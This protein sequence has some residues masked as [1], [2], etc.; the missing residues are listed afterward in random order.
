MKKRMLRLSI[1]SVLVVGSVIVL[2]Y[3]TNNQSLNIRNFIH[4]V[5]KPNLPFWVVNEFDPETEEIAVKPTGNYDSLK[6]DIIKKKTALGVRYKT[7]NEAE[8]AQILDEANELF[9]ES[10]LNQIIP[11]WYGTKWDYNGYTDVPKQGM[12]ACGYFVSTPL[13]HMGF[14]LNRYKLAQTYSLQAVK[15]LQGSDAISLTGQGQDSL[16]KYLLAGNDGFYAIGLDHHIGLLLKRKDKAYFIHSNNI[17]PG[18][19]C[20]ER[21]EKTIQVRF[22]EAMVLAKLSNN[23]TFL[24]KWILNEEF[25]VPT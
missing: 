9:T 10:L 14:N 1:I 22:S 19:V 20:I 4:K 18:T 21:A 17:W 16:V 6:A 15:V 3:A 5:T 8:K 12:V 23:T 24:R 13:K 2:P 11:H 25:K 7:A